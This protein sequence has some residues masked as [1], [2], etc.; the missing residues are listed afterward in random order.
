VAVVMLSPAEQQELIDG[1]PEAFAPVKGGWGERGA[2][3]VQLD[4]ADEEKVA[5]ALTM[6][7]KKRAPKSV[8]RQ[9]AADAKLR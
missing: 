1:D 3:Q 5:A 2:T 4:I 6:A 8:A 9:L 7:W